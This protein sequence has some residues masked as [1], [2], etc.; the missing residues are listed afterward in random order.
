M[1]TLAK[2]TFRGRS[3]LIAEQSRGGEIPTRLF[4]YLEERIKCHID[5]KYHAISPDAQR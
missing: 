2:M 1:A 5:R 4:F 3:K